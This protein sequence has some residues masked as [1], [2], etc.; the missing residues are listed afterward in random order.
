MPL[1][2]SENGNV[3]TK[4][5]KYLPNTYYYI[6][7]HFFDEIVQILLF[8]NACGKLCRYH[9]ITDHAIHYVD[10]TS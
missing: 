1:F 10:I 3:H 5:Y 4:I 9:L 6:F 7:R 2:F 8:K